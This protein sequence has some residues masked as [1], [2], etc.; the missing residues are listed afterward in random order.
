M[1]DTS[2]KSSDHSLNQKPKL[3]ITRTITYTKT[4]SVDEWSYPGRTALEA[5]A[6]EETRHEANRAQY[7]TVL[8][9]F[10][11]DIKFAKPQDIEIRTEVQVIDEHSSAAQTAIPNLPVD[12]VNDAGGSRAAT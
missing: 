6:Y 4:V 9:E 5:A 8:Y 10:S 7:D 2:E 12:A 1:P 11:D 3:S